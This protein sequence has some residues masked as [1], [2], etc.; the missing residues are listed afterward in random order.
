MNWRT[1]LQSSLLLFPLAAGA[2]E[3]ESVLNED[4]LIFLASGMEIEGEWQDPLS[5]GEM[6]EVEA[7][8]EK[9]EEN[10]PEDDKKLSPEQE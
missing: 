3:S 8:Q 7:L 6:A 9:D 5:L 10:M 2:Q 1:C 4:F